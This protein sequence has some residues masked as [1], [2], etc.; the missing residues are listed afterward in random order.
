MNCAPLAVIGMTYRFPRG[1]FMT[2][3][4]SARAD[5]LARLNVL[6]GEWREEVTLPGTGPLAVSGRTVFEWGLTYTRLT[7]R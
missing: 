1:G 2:V 5:A 6:V 4:Q 7:E 3:S